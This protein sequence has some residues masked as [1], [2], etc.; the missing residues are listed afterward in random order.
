MP[1]R[2]RA[3]RDDLVLALRRDFPDV[4]F[5]E[6][7]FDAHA[8]LICMLKSGARWAMLRQQRD[9]QAQELSGDY[10]VIAEYAT[11]WRQQVP[12][13]QGLILFDEGLN[14]VLELEPGIA[15]TKVRTWLLT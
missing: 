6:P 12:A 10:D 3:S 1:T 14:H 5:P 4:A 13:E 2:W 8:E 7:D 9:G 15:A 11:W